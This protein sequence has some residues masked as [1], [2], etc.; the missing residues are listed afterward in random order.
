MT[1]RITPNFTWDE[2]IK[3]ATASAKGIDNSIPPHLHVNAARTAQMMECVRMLWG[4]EPISPNSWYR[5]PALNDAI[6]GS[7]NS[8]H[9]LALACDFDQPDNWTL[10]AAFNKIAQSQLPYDKLI[11]ERTRD[12]AEWIHLG[13]S[14]VSIQPRRIL[15]AASGDRLGGEM[16]YRRVALG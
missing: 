9:T 14:E 2:V 6:G 7:D 13:L 5:C 15:L 12:G 10:E 3:S 4:N 8:A 11:I 16:F 1:G